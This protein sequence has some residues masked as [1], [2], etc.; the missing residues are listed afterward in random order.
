MPM[1][2]ALLPLSG[3]TE[4]DR[5][6]WRELADR[7][8]EPNPFFEP[9]YLLPLAQSFGTA[10][11]VRLLTVRDGD[12]WLACMPVNLRRRWH[13]IPIRTLGTWRGHDFFGLLGTPLVRSDRV[14]E[15]LESLLEA[16]PRLESRATVVALEWLGDGGPVADAVAP[17]LA[18]QA[19]Q[20]VTFESFERAILRR[21]P[22]PTYLEETLSSK[23]RRELRRQWRKLGEM[24]DDE[25]RA[26]EL[27]P[28]DAAVAQFV[29]LE[30]AG[31]KSKV[32]EPVAACPAQV[33]FFGEMCR[34]FARCGRL[35]LLALKA[36][37]ETV[38]MQCN[39]RA[40]STLFAL[41]V[42]Y[43]ERWARFS[44]GILLEREAMM[45]FHDDPQL[46]LMDACAGPNNGTINRLWPD[47]RTLTTLALP[48]P[49][50]KARALW[51]P[52]LAA[53]ALRNRRLERK[54]ML[55]Q[56]LGVLPLTLLGQENLLM[57]APY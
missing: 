7:A 10:A 42:A 41:K 51:P 4:T 38:A 48:T 15:T 23:R 43:D 57:A 20:A 34:E 53:R 22:E 44:P 39:L 56:P 46:D 11:E 33:A 9:G 6:A 3:L 45:L 2:T 52:L 18:D 28:G 36:G 29:A 47:R 21:R 19:P 16:L 25:P 31:R 8:A 54:E 5:R 1:E 14:P 40:G 35:Q 13:R 12:D 50:L 17:I 24:A 49:G 30:A 32:G 55:Q 26:V 37:E 27:P